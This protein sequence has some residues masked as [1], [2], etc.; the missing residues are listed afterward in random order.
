MHIYSD[1]ID[2][3]ST[4][5]DFAF[6]A[7]SGGETTISRNCG[8]IGVFDSGYG[9]LT[10]LRS[11]RKLMPEYDYIFLGDNA[12]APYGSRSFDVVYDF[13]L[14]G[15]EKLFELGCQLV[16][17]ACNTASAKA[18]RTIQQK[19]LP[20]KY[21]NRR[22][23]GVIRP[24]VE[25]LGSISKTRHIGL[26]ATTGTAN[27]H[28]YQ[29]EITKLYP[30]MKIEELGCPMWVPLVE[31][32]EFESDGADWFVKRYIDII[33]QQDPEIDTLILGCTHFPLLL[34]KIRKYVPENITILAQGDI[35]APSLKNYLDRHSDLQMRSTKGG[36]IQYL[37]TESATR[38]NQ[39][40][41]LF[42]GEAVSAE[43]IS[44]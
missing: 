26:L 13:T 36:T 21:P 29:M 33:L 27:S 15:V 9:G 39:L 35:V 40:S 37:T 3:K 19:I 2:A 22:V 8:P 16:I 38:F 44:L 5:P 11:I 30:D 18:L 10:I 32:G 7:K 31:Y 12:R 4:Q 34:P 43:R 14:Q 42:M 28:S 6:S 1:I 24:T 25:E 41:A 17:L 23:L 20:V